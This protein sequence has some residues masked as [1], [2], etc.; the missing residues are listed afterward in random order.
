VRVLFTSPAL[1][2]EGG[3]YGGGERYATELARAAAAQ[4]GGA[5]LYAA[6]TQDAER[7]DGALR[8]V[9]RRPRGHVR[10]QAS[11]PLPRG[12]WVE[13]RRADVV[14]CF[15]RHIVLTSAAIGMARLARRP[16]FVTDLGGGGWDV[17]AWV[18]TSRWC[19]GLLHLS[20]YARQVAGRADAPSDGV[21][22]GGARRSAGAREEDGS[23]LFVGRLLPHKGPDVLVEAADPAWRVVICGRRGDERYRA[24]LERLAAGKRVTFVEDA[25]DDTVAAHYRRAAVVV[26]PSTDVDRY[27]NRTAVAELLGL[28]AIE[29]AAHGVPVVASDVASLPEIVEDGVTGRLVPPH[30]TGALREAVAEL[31]SNPE[32][33]AAMGRAAAARA[34]AR[35]TWEQAAERA[36]AAYRAVSRR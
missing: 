35:F 18:D 3:V 22:L 21:L 27:G 28:T 8:V 31:L 16:V 33:R 9:V 20:A 25:A 14:H 36:V 26:V 7:Q 23:A 30:D 12:L 24:D 34:A 17:S 5:T 11:N 13:V 15:Q 29:A 6:G 10:G 2:G 1:F 4:L 19:A 32:R